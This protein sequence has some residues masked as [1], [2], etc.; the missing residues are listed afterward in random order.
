MLSDPL[1]EH[2]KAIMPE[3]VCQ[4]YKREGGG[5]LHAPT[6][7]VLLVAGDPANRSHGL[8]SECLPWYRQVNGATRRTA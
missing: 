5:V 7:P 8:S 2:R 3:V 4:G 6:C 1:S